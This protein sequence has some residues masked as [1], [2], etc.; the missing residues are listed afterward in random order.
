MAYNVDQWKGLVDDGNVI[1]KILGYVQ[2]GGRE[3]R[4]A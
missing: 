4:S 1:L 3:P 2:S